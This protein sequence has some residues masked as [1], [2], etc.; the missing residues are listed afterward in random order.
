LWKPPDENFL[1]INFDAGFRKTDGM[2]TCG[3]VVRDHLGEAVLA[4]AANV[5]PVRDALSA[6]AMGC[7]FAL[8]S[9]EAVGIS[10]I[11]LE[12]DCSQLQDA[13]MSQRRDPAPGGVLFRSIRE[14]LQDRF[15]CNKVIA[16]PRSC[17]SSAH[18]IAKLALSWDPGQSNVWNDPLPDFVCTHVARDFGELASYNERP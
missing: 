13:I 18:E 15:V 8:E 3:F 16:I 4:G 5:K 2:G 14:L 9:V 17:N 11:E 1:K 7:L 10:R 12:T 6:E